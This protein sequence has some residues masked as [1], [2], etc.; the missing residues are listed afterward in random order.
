LLVRGK[1]ECPVVGTTGK[2]RSDDVFFPGWGPNSDELRVMNVRLEKI[3]WFLYSIKTGI[4]WWL[5]V[6]KIAFLNDRHA[7]Q[8][9]RDFYRQLGHHFSLPVVFGATVP[10][11]IV[12]NFER[13]VQPPVEEARRI[14][15]PSQHPSFFKSLVLVPVPMYL[16]LS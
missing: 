7:T 8:A 14:I 12:S 2:S 13:A 9:M 6:L 1:K 11:L 10:K 16:L 4:R 5:N 3:G 15:Q